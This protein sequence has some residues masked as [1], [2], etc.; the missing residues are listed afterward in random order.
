MRGLKVPFTAIKLIFTTPKVFGL[1][2]IPLIINL[3]LYIL[4]FIH[5]SELMK[6]FI[7][8][9]IEGWKS[10]L[11]AWASFLPFIA[12][13]ALTLLS[14]ILL[15]LVSALSFTI[16]SSI[17]AAPFN[18]YLSIQTEV[19]FR[20]K[21]NY[22]A[23]DSEIRA[24]AM[25]TIIMEVKRSIVLIV[26]GIFTFILG[27]LPLMQIPAIILATYLISF[28]YYGIPFSRRTKNLFPVIGFTMKHPVLSFGFGG[29]L[30]LL[31]TIPFASII[32]IPLAVV[33]GSILYVEYSDKQTQRKLESST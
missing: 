6:S 32:Y 1:I 17:I 19:A 25:S 15:I 20:K 30:L 2:L 26:G 3:G 27:L 11:P 8:S 7:N 21:Y 5:G 31:M 9:F 28:E 12:S 24:S 14:W 23:L 29:F 18:D 10:D 13:F 22:P 33:S 4:L 16:I